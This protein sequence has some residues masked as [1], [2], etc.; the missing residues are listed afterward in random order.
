MSI[1]YIY[2]TKSACKYKLLHT[3]SADDLL[4][5][6]CQHNYLKILPLK[7]ALYRVYI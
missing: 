3:V 6:C 1:V 4:H 7:Q 5:N 2:Q